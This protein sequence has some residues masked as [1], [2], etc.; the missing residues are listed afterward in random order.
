MAKKII[1]NEV[2]ELLLWQGF[3]AVAF[4]ITAVFWPHLTT[5]VLLYIIGAYLL[6]S[7][8]LHIGSGVSTMNDR[9][10][11]WLLTTVLG[12]A[13]LGFGVWMLRHPTEVFSTFITLVGFVL[14]IRGLI[15]LVS[16]VFNGSGDVGHDKVSVFSGFLAI[17]AGILVLYQTNSASVAF[18]WIVGVYAI[19][20]GA[21]QLALAK[22]LSE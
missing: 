16:M 21:V 18:V 12:A 5:T 20:V 17:V 7:G 14:I 10:N 13:E 6:V 22:R 4:G 15:E 8:V 3:F 11:W 1:S 19:V 2:R 9:Q